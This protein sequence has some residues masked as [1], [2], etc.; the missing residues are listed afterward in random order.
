MCICE[1]LCVRINSSPACYRNNCVNTFGDVWKV[2]MLFGLSYRF[3][4]LFLFRSLLICYV[5]CLVVM[6]NHATQQKF[7]WNGQRMNEMVHLSNLTAQINISMRKN[8]SIALILGWNWKRT[9]IN[10]FQRQ[11][12]YKNVQKIEIE[13]NA[14]TFE[15]TIYLMRSTL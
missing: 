6:A 9:V 10:T 13:R 12:V 8:L 4:L 14:I 1:C 5:Y 2:L 7:G 15:S 11:L 3:L